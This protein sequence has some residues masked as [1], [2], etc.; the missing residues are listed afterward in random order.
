[1]MAGTVQRPWGSGVPG[2]FEGQ[3]GS[4]CD[5]SR[6]EWAER[7]RGCWKDPY[8]EVKCS[9]WI[10][11]TLISR[12]LPLLWEVGWVLGIVGASKSSALPL[13]T[14]GGLLMG[15]LGSLWGCVWGC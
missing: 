5:W 8:K 13:G 7:D 2:R 10:H 14:V 4:R 11:S 15:F 3:H 9:H 6:W 1:M 12:A